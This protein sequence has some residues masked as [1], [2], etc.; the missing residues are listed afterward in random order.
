[1]EG[2]ERKGADNNAGEKGLMELT[3][4]FL[5]EYSIHTRYLKHNSTSCTESEEEI[6]KTK[7]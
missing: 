7:L 1:M 6:K 5:Q 2:G 3:S 4:A